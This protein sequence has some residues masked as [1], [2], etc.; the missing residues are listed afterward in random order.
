MAIVLLDPDNTSEPTIRA[1]A[2]AYIDPATL[3]AEFA[4]IVQHTFAAQGLG[5][6]LA[7]PDRRRA[8]NAA[9]WKS[10]ATCSARTA[11]CSS[12]A[13]ISVSNATRRFTIPASSA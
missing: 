11:R 1:V 12:S 2:R 6:P 3:A 9:P 13:T 10:G 5:T 4:L 8:G 7:A